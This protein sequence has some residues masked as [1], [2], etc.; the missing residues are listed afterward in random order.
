MRASLL[1]GGWNGFLSVENFGEQLAEVR[2]LGLIKLSAAIFRRVSPRIRRRAHESAG[3]LVIGEVEK[4]HDDDLIDDGADLARH[5]CAFHLE[6]EFDEAAEVVGDF[7]E[8]AY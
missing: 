8:D 1:L 7:F 3:Q 2:R 4:F 5:F 6:S